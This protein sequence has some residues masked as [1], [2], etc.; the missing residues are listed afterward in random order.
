MQ[1]TFD[2]QRP[3]AAWLRYNYDSTC[4]GRPSDCLSKVI[5][6]TVTYGKPIASSDVN[7]DWTCKDKDN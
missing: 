3:N 7:K 5:K 6:F 4:V 2:I 1:H